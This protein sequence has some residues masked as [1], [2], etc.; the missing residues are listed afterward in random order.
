[1]GD[2]P[3]GHPEHSRNPL[4]FGQ[5]PEGV[6]LRVLILVGLVGAAIL[7]D[8]Q[9]ERESWVNVPQV[10]QSERAQFT[11]READRL[12]EQKRFSEAYGY[13]SRACRL[14]DADPA[15]WTGRA[16][17]ACELG[18]YG[19]AKRHAI[20]GLIRCWQSSHD[21]VRADLWYLRAVA[22]IGCKEN[23]DAIRD[24]KVCLENNPDHK[25]AKTLLK[26]QL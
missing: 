3:I 16:R 13:Y 11:C 25:L 20:Y 26:K 24:L 4:T 6:L 18:H 5:R 12:A 19:I 1:M 8:R 17:M 15:P 21:N 23:A 14:D 10:R 9:T 7:L 2:S 22:E